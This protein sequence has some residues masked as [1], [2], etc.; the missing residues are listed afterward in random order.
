MYSSYTAASFARKHE[1]A[2]KHGVHLEGALTWAFEFEEQPL[3]AGFRVLSSNGIALPVLNVFRMFG[4]M[5]GQRLAVESTAEVGLDTILKDGVRDRPDVSALAALATGKLSVLLWHYHDDDVPGPD[6]A[7]QLTLNSLPLR[8]G[9][10]QMQHFR[11]DQD[12]S[13]A[14]SAWQRM[15]S[16]PTLSAEQQSRLEE[17]SQLTLLEAPST[18]CIENGAVT[19]SL[20]LPRQAVSLL[21]LEW[22]GA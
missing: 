13:N 22:H 18:V 6:A 2:H 11:I 17:H 3:F 21:L 12:R 9:A 7:V 10:A 20:T 8:D 5:S 19:L 4:K 14:Y 16:P 1:L 15:G